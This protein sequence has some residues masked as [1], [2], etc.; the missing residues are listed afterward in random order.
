MVQGVGLRIRFRRHPEKAVPQ[1]REPKPLP[2][3]PSTLHPRNLKPL[4]LNLRTPGPTSLNL[5]WL[6]KVGHKGSC[7][8]LSINPTAA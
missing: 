1:A 8:M 6:A 3:K 5:P 2:L 7:R 4:T